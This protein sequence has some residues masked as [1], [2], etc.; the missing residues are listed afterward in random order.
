MGIGV[1]SCISAGF[2]FLQSLGMTLQRVIL[3]GPTLFG[4]AISGLVISGMASAEEL[5]TPDHI[6]PT[7]EP[8]QVGYAGED[9][10]DIARYL[11]ARGAQSMVL[12]PDGKTIAMRY[13]VTGVPQ[14]WVVTVTGGQPQQLTFGNG[15]TFFRW[16]PDSNGLIY[17]ADNDGNEQPSYSYISVDGS[18]EREVLPAVKGG[19]RVFGGFS[20][21]GESFAFASTERNGSDFDIYSGDTNSGKT[22]RV[23]KGKYGFFVTALSPDGEQAVLSETVG[24]DANNLYILNM[25]SG[26]IKA[27]SIPS[28]RANHTSGTVKWSEDGKSLWLASNV[29]REFSALVR[30]DLKEKK[31]TTIF[32]SD[33][34]VGDVSLCGAGDKFIAWTTNHDGF[35]K[36]HVMDRVL[37]EFVDPIELEAGTYQL[38]CSREDSVMAILVNSWKTPGDILTW[39]LESDGVARIFN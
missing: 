24:E 17:G 3:A 35:E 6:S 12:S 1:K 14:I 2:K 21:N 26:K 16:H 39:N 10:A 5:P 20:K 15:V 38:S 22:K 8:I 13:S 18:V 27:I 37:R 31:F 7:N 11:L 36:L 23:Y 9:P 29:G 32:E 30:Y 19:F 28:P 33:A 4:L 34:D 25:Q